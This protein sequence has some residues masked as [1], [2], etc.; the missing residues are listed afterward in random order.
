M[1]SPVAHDQHEVNFWTTC[2]Q[3]VLKVEWIQNLVLSFWIP[4]IRRVRPLKD[5]EAV[6]IPTYFTPAMANFCFKELM[7]RY[8]ESEDSA[9][10]FSALS[11]KVLPEVCDKEA[12]E[13]IYRAALAA[14]IPN[15]PNGSSVFE[16]RV[17]TQFFT[18]NFCALLIRRPNLNYCIQDRSHM[19]DFFAELHPSQ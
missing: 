13:K 2:L 5:L 8:I 3:F 6:I 10:A 12:A 14:I 9:G 7:D 17:I 18:K 11:D 16:G 1:T 4:D 15:I 19:K